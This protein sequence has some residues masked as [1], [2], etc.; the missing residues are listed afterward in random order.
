M[1]RLPEAEGIQGLAS[2]GA[3][4]TIRLIAIGESTIAGVGVPTHDVGFTGTLAKELARKLKANVSW[5][6]YAKS[7]YTARRVTEKIIS[8]I[9][10]KEIDLII[11]GLGGNDAFALNSPNRW[12][13]DIEEL[14]LALKEKYG[15]TPIVFTN[16]PPIKEFPAFT[17]AMKCIL[18]NL[19][20]LL[21]EKLEQ[22]VAKKSHVYYR[23][24]NITL[25]DWI[26][27]MNIEHTEKDFFSD[28]V[29]P[30]LLTYQTWAKDFSDFIIQK[31][32]LK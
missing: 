25:K 17:S 24:Q 26:A 31:T 2:T 15:T 9:A 10:E 16:M 13:R 23:S 12:G 30:S 3:N 5:R 7:G 22:V 32:V 4:R 8:S 6:V 29:H 11:V 18:G 27:R 20:E 14:I 28:G 21:G 1:P 19:V